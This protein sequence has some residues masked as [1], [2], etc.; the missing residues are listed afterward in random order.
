[1]TERG[2]GEEKRGR[3]EKGR[4]EERK[5]GRGKEEEGKRG[6][7]EDGKE[8]KMKPE[9]ET[10]KRQQKE[11]SFPQKD[12]ENLIIYILRFSESVWKGAERHQW[13]SQ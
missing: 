13:W 6:R 3:G 9:A 7:G 8:E 4:G 1:M 11:R 5:R 12:S 2:G 10:T